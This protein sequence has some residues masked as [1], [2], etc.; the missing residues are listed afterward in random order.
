[1][2]KSKGWQPIHAEEAFADPVF[3]TKPEVVPAGAD[4]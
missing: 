3:S 2:S 4:G 1:M